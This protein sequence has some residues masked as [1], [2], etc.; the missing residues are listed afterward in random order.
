MRAQAEPSEMK[1]EAQEAETMLPP[2]LLAA[3]SEGFVFDAEGDPLPLHSNI[4]IGDATVLYRA[5]REI[6]PKISAEVG[7][8][9]GISALAILKALADNAS[10]IHHII[11]PFQDHYNDIGLAMV[12]RAGLSAWMQFHRQ[13]ADAVIPN[14]PDLEFGFID[15]S[16]LFDFTVCE[17]VMMDRKLKIGGMI[18]IHNMQMPAMQKFLRCI[19]ANRSYEMVR[20]FDSSGLAN[21]RRMS[22][23][24]K[25]FMLR[26]LHLIPGKERIFRAEVLTPW[27]SMQIQNLVVLRK[28]ASDDRDSNF[29]RRF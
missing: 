3:F 9:Q 7:F 25:Q 5:V 20:T 2:T 14:L 8:A 21:A 10:G 11:D 4:S 24:P 22:W 15:S 17:F 23:A 29:Y 1:D 27:K 6:K 28:T 26:A 12:E 19:L 13:Y 18:A 16:H